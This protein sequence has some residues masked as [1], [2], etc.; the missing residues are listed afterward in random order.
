[1]ADADRCVRKR[2]TKVEPPA[3]YFPSELSDDDE[4]DFDASGETSKSHS[5]TAQNKPLVLVV[6]NDD[7]QRDKDQLI[8]TL[9]NEFELALVDSPPGAISFLQEGT[10]TPKIIV[11]ILQRCEESDE[12][13]LLTPDSGLS[14]A[15]LVRDSGYSIPIVTYG[16][17]FIR[18]DLYEAE[19]IQL[20]GDGMVFGSQS[21][22]D[23][24][25]KCIVDPSQISTKI[26]LEESAVGRDVDDQIQE[27]STSI[28]SDSSNS[29]IEKRY[30]PLPLG[31]QSP[32]NA[33]ASDSQTLNA[34][35]TDLDELSEQ[36]V[37]AI[38]QMADADRCVRKRCTKVE[39]PAFYFPSELS[40]EDELSK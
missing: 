33:D 7:N 38:D 27:E 19:T 2:C 3:F 35:L 12:D 5:R 25:S 4:F 14:F 28:A 24:I 1:M 32:S 34:R 8:S 13:L 31:M 37:D 23:V 6:S 22:C 29:S 30:V 36:S 10:A 20:N 15:Q 18:L 9:N 11:S 21:L 16:S 39:P 40:D 17:S 26:E